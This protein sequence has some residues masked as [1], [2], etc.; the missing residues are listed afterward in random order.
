MEKVELRVK[1]HIDA[2]W[3]DWLEGLAV[4]STPEGNTIISGKVADDSA[5]YGL[6]NR[7]SDLGLKLVS[8]AADSTG[9]DVQGGSKDANGASP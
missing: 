6:L 5:L 3:S 2:S 8:L 9:N 1:G 7:L 4:T